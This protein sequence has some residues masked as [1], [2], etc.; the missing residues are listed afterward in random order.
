MSGTELSQ[1]SIS[2]PPLGLRDLLQR[3]AGRDLIV[4]D[5]DPLLPVGANPA[6]AAHHA[7]GPE[8]IALDPQ[9]IE[10]CHALLRSRRCSTRWYGTGGDHQALHLVSARMTDTQ[11]RPPLGHSLR[12]PMRPTVLVAG[13][14]Q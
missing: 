9:P 5:L 1:I 14:L 6:P 10:A 3:P 4:V 7:H 12:L 2:P 11:E 13:G 8:N